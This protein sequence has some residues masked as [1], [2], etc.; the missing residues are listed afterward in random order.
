MPWILKAMNWCGRALDSRDR[1]ELSP[2]ILL[3]PP[4]SNT[5]LI[6]RL[7]AHHSEV[8][9]L[10]LAEL[11]FPGRVGALFRRAFSA[12]P[13]PWVDHFYR[14]EIHAAG[15]HMPEADDIALMAAFSEGVFSW[16]YGHALRR[17]SEPTLDPERHLAYLDW[18]RS[19]FTRRH[20]GKTVCSKYFAGVHHFD[21][22]AARIPHARFVLLHRDPESVCDSLCTLLGAALAARRIAID[23]PAIYWRNIYDFLVRTYAKILELTARADERVLVLGDAQ[24][25]ADLRGCIEAICRHAGL[26]PSRD[27]ALEREVATKTA[28]G[29][30]LKNYKYSSALRDIFDRRDFA[31][32]ELVK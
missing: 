10:P 2:I 3:G 26:P 21:A 6:H 32:Y 25:K 31:G 27:H 29:R 8:A 16:A 7:L 9:A 20:P 30:Y 23:N 17:T 1:D 12:V 11:V 13:Q 14:P 19:S 28:G 15:A 5:T 18:L 24:V 22:L 4:R